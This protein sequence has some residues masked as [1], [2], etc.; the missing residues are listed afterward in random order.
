MR[1][2]GEMGIMSGWRRMGDPLLNGDT[3]LTAIPS[4]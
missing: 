4:K 2:D 1:G 3:T